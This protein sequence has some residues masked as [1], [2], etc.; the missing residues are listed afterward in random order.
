MELEGLVKAYNIDGTKNKRG[1]IKSY[2]N[3]KFS[4]NRKNFKER[5]YVTRLRKQKIILELPWLK[6]HNLEINW[7]TGKL[8]MVNPNQFEM[9]LCL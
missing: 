8:K 1:T 4:L 6:E 7:K 2:V 9:I 5:F 3:L